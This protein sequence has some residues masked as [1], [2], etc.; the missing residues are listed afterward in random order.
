LTAKLGVFLLTV[1]N[2]R[3][4]FVP[5]KTTQ[6]KQVMVD[7]TLRLVTKNIGCNLVGKCLTGVIVTCEPY[8]LKMSSLFSSRNHAVEDVSYE[9]S[10]F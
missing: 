10:G 2:W 4:C 5:K 3:N 6:Q 7:L 8:P 9:H 1:L